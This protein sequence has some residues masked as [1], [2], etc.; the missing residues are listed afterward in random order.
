[1]KR[2]YTLLIILFSIVAANP[3]VAAPAAAPPISKT[4]LSNGL[5][6]IVKPEPGTGL[7][8]IEAFVKAGAPQERDTQVGIG[9]LVARALL[10][11][12]RS[13]SQERLAAAF[14]EVG[15]AFQTDWSP[16]VT[17]VSAI[18]TKQG[19]DDAM[20]IIADV[21]LNAEFDP[22]V[23]QRTQRAELA[24]IK[25]SADDVAGSA[26]TQL[27]EA[28]YKDNPYR[29]P[30][31]GYA[32]SVGRLTRDDLLAFYRKYYVPSNMVISVAGDVTT[33]QVV[34][35]LNKAFAGSD[36]GGSIAQR[37]FGDETLTQSVTKIA[38]RNIP[39]AYIVLGFLAPGVSNPDFPALVVA[40]AILG[41]G[42][43]SRLFTG[44]REKRGIGY[45]IGSIYPIF[46]LQSHLA[47][48]LVTDL[49]KPTLP[50]FPREMAL[51]DAKDAILKEISLLKDQPVSDEELLRAKRYVIGT[52]ALRHQRLRERAYHLGWMEAIGVGYQFDLNYDRI[53]DSVTKADVQRVARKYLNNY[54]MVLSLPKS[55]L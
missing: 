40:N 29:R 26:Y 46:K 22:T 43:A 14:D 7:I 13:R 38:E 36:A 47:A 28:L 12:T 33:E 45:E 52:Y 19:F 9:N 32:S 39:A 5:V 4:V 51:Q 10:S 30:K 20:N 44:V 27:L 1:M 18:T 2:L 25:R 31:S 16:D 15:G 24:D 54:A 41:G 48:M 17:D 53:I 37:P 3:L 21:L 49:Y 55:S 42:K 50:G 35:R 8:A 6:A 34:E 23:V 11:S